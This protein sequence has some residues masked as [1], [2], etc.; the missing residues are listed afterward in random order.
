MI[1]LNEQQEKI[2]KHILSLNRSPQNSVSIGLQMDTY[3]A[4]IEEQELIKI[5]NTLEQNN[6][7]KIKWYGVSRSDLNYAIDIFILPE[8]EN[9]FEN[10]KSLQISNRREWVRSYLPVTIS[11]IAL[12]KS[13]SPEIKSI[14]T[15]LMQLWK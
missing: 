5:L 2:L 7:I 3:P 13:F 9:Y 12:I 6:F 11:F 4:D 15:L 10:K 14:W 8:C 1:K